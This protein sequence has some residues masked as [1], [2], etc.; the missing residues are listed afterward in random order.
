MNIVKDIKE[1]NL[2]YGIPLNDLHNLIKH[3]MYSLYLLIY[4]HLA[5]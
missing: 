5:K 4:H 3:F 2:E 1:K